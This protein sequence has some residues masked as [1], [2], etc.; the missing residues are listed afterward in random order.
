[1]SLYEHFRKDE[2]PFIDQV[3]D[4]LETVENEYRTKLTDFLDPR[5]QFIVTS[6]TGQG[7]AVRCAFFGGADKAERRRA[8]LY[9]DYIEPEKSLF[10]L[11]AFELD[12]PSKFV[13]MTHPQ[14]L[15]A[16]L[17][18]GLKRGKFGDI[19]I[20]SNAVQFVTCADTA[21]YVEQ[22]FREAGRAPVLP[23][24]IELSELK[25]PDEETT[26]VQ[27]TVSSL[28][29]DTVTSELYRL[30]RAKTKPLIQQEKVKVNWK[31]TDDPSF[32]IEE[33]DMI[34]VRGMGRCKIVALGGTTRK[35][36]TVLK[37]EKIGSS[38]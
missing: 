25:L 30:S 18:L 1:M 33:G 10:E 22:H 20:S 21:D 14:V 3:T 19:M 27:V 37:A 32:R 6:L 31:I 26:D 11:A 2:H 34:S 9:P 28:R 7:N 29:L 15:G 5:Q 12:F 36:N 17:S 24:R 4:W 8:L 13:R 38:S 16:L 23:K 35:G